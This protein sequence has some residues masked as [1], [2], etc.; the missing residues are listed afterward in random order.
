MVSH[1][2]ARLLTSFWG[3]SGYGRIFVPIN[4][5]LHAEEIRYI[6][7]HCGAS[8]LLVDPELDEALAGRAGA[9]PAGAGRRHRR[10]A[11]A[12]RRARPGAVDARRGH[13]RDDQLHVGHDRS[14]QGRAADP[15]RAVGQRHDVRLAHRRLRPRR[16]PAHAA[17]VPLQRLGH[18]VL[19][20]RHGRAPRSCCARSTARR[21][22]AASTATASRCMCGAPAV[23]AAILDAA[24][25]WD[26][27][28]ARARAAPAS[29]WRARRRRPAR[30][31]ASRPSWAGSSSRSTASPRPR[32]S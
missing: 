17:D 27:D 2:A 3:V 28:G 7:G 24:K 20:R 13:H 1:N 23:V 5:R 6:V 29:S 25:D 15:P 8:V 22:C 18:A 31:S 4:F 11:V 30:S 26:G 9:A 32:R 14:A 10:A 21:S 19:D 16:L 12:V